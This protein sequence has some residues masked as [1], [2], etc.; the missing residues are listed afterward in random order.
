MSYI[1]KRKDILIIFPHGLGDFIHLSGVFKNLFNT[2]KVNIYFALT[3]Y[4][5]SAKLPERYTFIK[6]IIPL[7]NPYSSY[8]IKPRID[9]IQRIIKKFEIYFDEVF[10]IKLNKSINSNAIKDV[11]KIFHINPSNDLKPFFP[12][13]NKEKKIALQL[14]PIYKINSSKK[15]Y[16]RH[17]TSSDMRRNV[18][19]KVNP[20][21]FIEIG[22]NYNY[23][24]WPLGVA[25]Y[26]M[27]KS[28]HVELVD[29]CMLHIAA[30]IKKDVD[31]AYLTENVRKDGYT[32]PPDLEVKNKYKKNINTESRF[33]YILN[34]LRISLRALIPFITLS[35][36]VV[37]TK[38]YKKFIISIVIKKQTNFFINKCLF[39]L[40]IEDTRNRVVYFDLLINFPFSKL[41]DNMDYEKRR[42]LIKKIIALIK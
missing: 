38:N 5:I 27:K 28:N 40:K 4:V 26:L 17:L 3:D 22:K 23:Q 21:N 16:F 12:I 9:S 2:K 41:F 25:A 8:L 36:L 30:A 14:L 19:K 34:R 10:D 32:P 29:S 33:K 18:R 20:E 35:N 31:I 13:L 11:S 1:V 24:K 6:G 39:L 7:T 42:S 15:L 37:K